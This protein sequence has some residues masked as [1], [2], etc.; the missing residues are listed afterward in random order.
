MTE[1][2]DDY[3]RDGG[4]SFIT[5]VLW[6]VVKK[7]I[8]SPLI[9]MVIGYVIFQDLRKAIFFAL[10]IY[11][12]IAVLSLILKLFSLITSAMTFRLIKVVKKSL[13]VI[14]LLITLVIYW[15]LYSLYSGAV[16]T[17]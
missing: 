11:T 14:L 2:Y 4:S 15:S 17:L 10:L 9:A 13:D 7:A 5:K 16:F 12:G 6:S 1:Q 8:F 3:K